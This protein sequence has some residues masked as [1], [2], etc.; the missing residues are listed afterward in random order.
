MFESLQ[1]RLTYLFAA[2][3][4]LVVVSI[5]AMMWGSETQRQDAVLINLAGR[6]RM[7]AQQMARLAFEGEGKGLV[8]ST[9]LE[10]EQL[11]DPTQ[12]ALLEGGAAP[13]PSGVPVTLPAT[14]DLALRSALDQTGLAWNDFRTLL[15][16]SQQAARAGALPASTLNSIEAS[17]SILVERRCGRAPV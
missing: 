16:Q 9:L 12:R 6:Q 13:Y 3:V 5:G 4:L 17:A 2:F 1:A 7:L 11:F 10:A 14:R 15:D 8:A